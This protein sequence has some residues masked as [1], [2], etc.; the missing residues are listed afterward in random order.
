MRRVVLTLLMATAALAAGTALA[1]EGVR[2]TLDSPSPLDAPAG[3][4]VRVAWHLSDGDGRPFG[5]GGIYLRVSRCGAR[6]LRIRA[7][8]LG[9]GAYSARFKVPKR[10]IRKLM[11][12]LEGWR[13]I[14]EK[15]ER[16]DAVFN[17]VPALGRRCP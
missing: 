7:R 13:T 11:V 12:G 9:G 6:P 8:E 5:A 2:A 1:K 14:G 4:T 10:G 17:F 16:A 15:T 3:K